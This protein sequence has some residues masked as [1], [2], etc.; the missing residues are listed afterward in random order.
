M[1]YR[2]AHG[3]F[4]NANPITPLLAR[5]PSLPFSANQATALKPRVYPLG[6]DQPEAALGLSEETD[7]L[8]VVVSEETAA[9]TVAVTGRLLRDVSST[10]VR[11]LV[12]GRPIRDVISSATGGGAT[13]GGSTGGG[14]ETGGGGAGL[15]ISS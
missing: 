8:V 3:P 10:Q 1:G 7:A 9:I 14:S 2:A 15:A 13:G 12:A 6:T 11:D 5:T 4:S